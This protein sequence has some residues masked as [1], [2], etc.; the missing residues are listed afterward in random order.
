MIRG[1]RSSG[2]VM[3]VPLNG[4]VVCGACRCETCSRCGK[5]Q[6]YDR[7]GI[8]DQ[9]DRLRATQKDNSRSGI[10]VAGAPISTDTLP[11]ILDEVWDVLLDML[12]SNGIDDESETTRYN[13]VR[14]GLRC[15]DKLIDVN[16]SRV[17]KELALLKYDKKP[18]SDW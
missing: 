16:T 18:M 7:I 8:H 10:F 14:L 6:I 3:E 17:D 13:K 11:R 12:S 1:S 9:H 5:D 4:C 15:V 2:P